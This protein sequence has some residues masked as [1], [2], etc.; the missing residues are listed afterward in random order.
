LSD[1]GEEDVDSRY[2]G[3][4]MT[5]EVFYELLKMIKPSWYPLQ[6]GAG[7]NGKV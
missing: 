1:E 7:S 2:D 3:D 4:G 6:E 5:S